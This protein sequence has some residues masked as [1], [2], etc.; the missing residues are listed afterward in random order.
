MIATLQCV[1]LD[2]PDPRALAEFYRSLLGGEVDKPTRHWAVG[3]DWATLHLPS[4]PH[5]LVLE[6]GGTLLR[7]DPRGWLIFADP[8]GHP[9]CVLPG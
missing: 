8:A 5:D 4:G 9:F 2:C 3:P 1:V 7:K 6:L